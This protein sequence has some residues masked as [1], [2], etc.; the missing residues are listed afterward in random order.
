MDKHTSNQASK[1]IDFTRFKWTLGTAGWSIHSPWLQ[2]FWS[3]SLKLFQTFCSGPIVTSH[4]FTLADGKGLP[5]V[6]LF[7]FSPLLSKLNYTPTFLLTLLFQRKE[8]RSLPELSVPVPLLPFLFYHGLLSSFLFC[9]LN[10]CPFPDFWSVY[11][12]VWGFSFLKIFLSSLF[13]FKNFL[14]LSIRKFPT[15]I[16]S[17][18]KSYI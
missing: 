4:P 15:I 9:I 8:D 14:F 7:N 6:S 13:Y 12:N 16:L 10:L 11:E 1:L 17:F 3:Y 18:S 2:E 5:K